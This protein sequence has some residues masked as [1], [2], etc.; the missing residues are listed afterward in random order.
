MSVVKTFTFIVTASMKTHFIE[1][2]KFVANATDL[3][4]SK[5]NELRR[6]ECIAV[7]AVCHCYKS[8]LDF[9]EYRNFAVHVEKFFDVAVY[10]SQ[11]QVKKAVDLRFAAYVVDCAR[12]L[13]AKQYA[14]SFFIFESINSVSSRC[15]LLKLRVH[16]EIA[17]LLDAHRIEVKKVTKRYVMR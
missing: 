7:I 6:L 8:M 3:Q 11:L 2:L 9:V 12:K 17:K 5:L 13:F 16:R 10:S 4:L 1:T 14:A 15:T